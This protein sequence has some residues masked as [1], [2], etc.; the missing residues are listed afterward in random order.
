MLLLHHGHAVSLAAQRGTRRPASCAG[1]WACWRNCGQITSSRTSPP[2]HDGTGRAQIPSREKEH[3][4]ASLRGRFSCTCCVRRLIE[5]R[6]LSTPGHRRFGDRRFRGFVFGKQFARYRRRGVGY[7][8]RGSAGPTGASGRSARCRLVHLEG[9][10]DRSG[11]AVRPP[12]Q[13]A[14]GQSNQRVTELRTSC[15]IT[16]RVRETP[17]TRSQRS[18]PCRGPW[19]Q[20]RESRIFR[21]KH[22]S[23]TSSAG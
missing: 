2:A 20:Q 18:K 22:Q 21:R 17:S 7:R 8:R 19:R 3:L 23:A 5:Q 4:S 13:F 11:R 14:P 10:A 16:C 6:G 1:R 15:R 9:L 12:A